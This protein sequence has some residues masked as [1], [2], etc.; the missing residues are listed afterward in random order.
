MVPSGGVVTRLPARGGG[1]G[2]L[3]TFSSAT[4][5]I[6]ETAVAPAPPR[7][8]AVAI[9]T[10][11][12]PFRLFAVGPVGATVRRPSFSM[13]G[14]TI[15]V[16]GRPA[17]RPPVPAPRRP[18]AAATPFSG[19]GVAGRIKLFFSYC[20]P[21]WGILVWVA[22]SP[23][24]GVTPVQVG[25][26]IRDAGRRPVAPPMGPVVGAGV[27]TFDAHLAGAQVRPPVAA[28]ARVPLAPIRPGVRTRPSLAV[29]VATDVVV[30]PPTGAA[31]LAAA[32]PSPGVRRGVGV[33]VVRP[34]VVHAI[35]AA[36]GVPRDAQDIGPETAPRRV[37]QARASAV[38]AGRPAP[39]AGRAKVALA[40]PPPGVGA[41]VVAGGVAPV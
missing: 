39:D 18:P 7:T 32:A 23:T 29:T 27:K 30:P 16:T 34:T 5:L 14:A 36:P 6:K 28:V 15:L 20:F 10:G 8:V 2:V 38:A 41:T 19:R 40:P 35:L 13:Q 26:V 22:S 37:E 9:V 21:P 24:G 31:G 1:H 12:T 3:A 17:C 11:H 33:R 25:Q 4:V